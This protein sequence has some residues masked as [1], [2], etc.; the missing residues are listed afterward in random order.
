M[1]K[2]TILMRPLGSSFLSCEKDAE[3]II[4]KLFVT[5]KP[6]SDELKRL[7]VINTK[8]CLDKSNQNYNKIIESFSVKEL[9]KDKYIT[10]I[11]KLKMKEHEEVKSYIILTFD[12]FIPTSNPEFRDCTIHFDIISFTDYWDLGDYQIRPI[13]IA[14]IIDG[15][16]NNCKLS[17]IGTLNFA[18]MEEVVYSEDLAGYSIMFIATHG[19]DDQIEGE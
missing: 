10:L 6:Y 7:L 19:S 15:I 17:G 12:N 2:D 11:P 4:K 18:G 14:G 8:D 5:S 13:K 16:L 3:T 9:M 1:K